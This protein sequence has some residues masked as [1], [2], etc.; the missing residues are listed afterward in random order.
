[1]LSGLHA[2]NEGGLQIL[3][4][5]PIAKSTVAKSTIAKSAG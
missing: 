5:L 4:V 2:N 1:M 3:Y